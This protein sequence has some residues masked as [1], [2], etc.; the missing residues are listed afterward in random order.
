MYPRGNTPRSTHCS[1][2]IKA[3]TA[4]AASGGHMAP[5][6]ASTIN[7]PT[8]SALSNP[9]QGASLMCTFL[10]KYGYLWSPEDSSISSDLKQA[11]KDFCLIML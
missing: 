10:D 8:F 9:Q 4:A 6:D 7:S 11:V 3:E 5:S 1:P 2:N